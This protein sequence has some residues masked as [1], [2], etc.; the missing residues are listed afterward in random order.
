LRQAVRATRSRPAPVRMPGA[1]RHSPVLADQHITR[2]RRWI[3][4]ERDLA[5]DS[6]RDRTP[7]AM[8]SKPPLSLS[9]SETT[10]C[11]LV[12]P[13]WVIARFAQHLFG[14]PPGLLLGA[15][16]TP[17]SCCQQRQA[18]LKPVIQGGCCRFHHLVDRPDN[19]RSM[20]N[21]PPS[22]QRSRHDVFE[23]TMHSISRAAR[24]VSSR[25]RS[26]LASICW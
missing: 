3:V 26:A 1:R 22:R 9:V 10:G 2:T 7:C 16:P 23:A 17:W 15:L 8:T 11:R 13:R 20:S 18:M 24:P 21:P 12:S 25:I 4:G 6:R 5:K 14:I 19:M